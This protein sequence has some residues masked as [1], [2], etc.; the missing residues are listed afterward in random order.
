MIDHTTI[1]KL[2]AMRLSGMA[3]CLD[4]IAANPDLARL[5]APRIVEMAVDWEWER[6][7]DSKLSRLRRSAHLAQPGAD[8]ADIQQLPG[9]RIDTDQIAR[10][11]VGAYLAKHQDVIIQGPTGVGKTYIAC[12][13]ANKACQQY[14]T[15]AYLTAPELFD[16]LAVAD[17]AGQRRQVLDSLTRT[18]LLVI[19]DWFL[20]AP[21]REQARNLHVLVD[22]RHRHAST[23]YCTQLGPDQWHDRIEEKILADAIIDRITTNAHTITL[24]TGDS[25]RRH[26]NQL[27]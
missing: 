7:Q 10:L 27:D 2:R 6:R 8:V 5:P 26:Y 13:L 25:L 16:K 23:I 14:Q 22:R 18:D 3:A 17:R 4:N 21:N 9:R 20:T 12:A 24:D 15:V 11:A 19:D 1:V